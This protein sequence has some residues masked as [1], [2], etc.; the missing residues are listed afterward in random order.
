[1]VIALATACQSTAEQT[2]QRAL[3]GTPAFDHDAHDARTAEVGPLAHLAALPDARAVQLDENATP[4]FV[5]GD[6]GRIEI[7]S[8]LE[9]TRV[10]AA[11]AAIAPVFQAEASELRLRRA[12]TDAQGDHHLRFSRV[13]DGLPVFGAEL[14]LHVRDGVIIAANGSV[15][16]DVASADAPTLGAADALRAARDGT[17]GADITASGEPRLAYHARGKQLALVYQVLVEGADDEGFPIRDIVLVDATDGS[18]AQRMPQIHPARSRKVHSAANGTSVPGT[19]I[20]SEGGAAVADATVNTNYGIL[21]N[22][23][24]CYKNLFNRDSYDGAGA[25]INS[26]VHYGVQW[27]GA[28]WDDIAKHLV[29]GDSDGVTFDAMAHSMDITAHEFTHAVTAAES[30]LAFTGESG[31]LNESLS[32]IFGAVCEW[33]RDGQV[34]TTNTWLFGEDITTPG[35]PGDGLRYMAD[36]AVDGYSLDL[37]DDYLPGTYVQF[38][39]GIGNLA[40]YLLAQGGTHPRGRTT[41]TVPGIGI[42]KAAKVFYEANIHF[43]MS[44]STYADAR[45]ATVQAAVNLGY[46]P[47]EMDAVSKAWEAVGIPDWTPP[48]APQLQNNVPLTGLSGATGSKKYYSVVVPPGATNLEFL[49]T[50]GTG[51]VDLSVR[52]EGMPTATV[53]DCRPYLPGNVEAC[54]SVTAVPGRYFIMLEAYAAYAGVTL[55]VSY[56]NPTSHL[57]INEIDYDN[58]S[59]DNNEYVEIYN[60]TGAPVDLAGYA[61]AFINGSDGA[62]YLSA[63]LGV[64]GVLAAGQYLVVGSKTVSVAAG[65]KKI[66]FSGSQSNRIQN[67]TEGVVLVSGSSVIDKVS[68]EGSVT[69]AIIP[70]VGTVNLVEGTAI[71]A[72]K[73]DS[74]TA[75]RVLARVP[76][77]TDT[78]N[79]NADWQASSTLSPGAANP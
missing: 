24:D 72:A 71:A 42:L 70:G 21:G 45:E 49:T 3:E 63:D 65:A 37:Y 62:V 77:G 13:K 39:S 68:Y 57:V 1:M 28:Y 27:G 14:V 23:Y 34:V 44:S 50:G 55:K 75:A 9:D 6:L 43:L 25:V 48:S 74:N 20:R 5:T 52:L 10:D 15:G 41:V 38:A 78:D 67:D 26:T 11:L 54:S 69:A 58:V 60:P 61:L 51:D 18:I 31:A 30:G 19:L 2:E 32:D 66:E 36:P 16:G 35:T 7:A 79:A 59:T 73:A 40:F 53:N 29:Y 56:T 47:A 76:N 33:Y 22:T 4:R 17:D 12:R 8:R 46:T 64:A